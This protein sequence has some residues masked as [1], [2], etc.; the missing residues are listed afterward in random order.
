MQEREC[1]RQ[2]EEGVPLELKS[3]EQYWLQCRNVDEW[4]EWLSRNHSS[5]SA[6]WLKIR[7]AGSSCEGVLL[8]DAVTEAIAFGL[9]IA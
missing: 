2:E 5:T 4:H 3:S 1:S 8:K 9:C 7:K 6:V